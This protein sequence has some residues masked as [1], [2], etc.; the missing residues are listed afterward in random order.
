MPDGVT[1]IL[2]H[3]ELLDLVRF[4]SE[5][6]KPGP[7]AMPKDVTIK[8]WKRLRDVPAILAEGT[9]HLEALR[10]GLLEQ[11]ASAF[12]T[13]YSMLHGE[14]PLDELRKPGASSQ[15]VYLIGEVEV[16]RPGKLDVVVAGP[17]GTAFWV[18]DTPTEK[19]GTAQVE[20]PGGR[21]RIVVRTTTADAAN[22]R[23][24]LRKPADSA[25]Q[26]ELPVAVE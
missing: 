22:L 16:T 17:A 1:R 13:V 20:A 19:A 5:L 18:N 12:D 3:G 24:E 2:A 14:V 11:P 4:V 7:F 6:G 10:T 23:V 26:F 9:P 15:V 21:T 25:V 8:T